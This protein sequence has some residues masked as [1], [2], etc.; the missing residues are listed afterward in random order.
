MRKLSKR[1][2][3]KLERHRREILNIIAERD[4]LRHSAFE[5]KIMLVDDDL[6]FNKFLER[7]FR[8][9]YGFRV[10]S[11]TD[12]MQVIAS[13]E[14]NSV[15][16]FVMD[17]N[18][19]TITGDKLACVVRVLYQQSQVPILFTSSNPSEE[20]TVCEFGLNHTYFLPKPICTKELMAMVTEIE[21]A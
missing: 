15:D 19:D 16:L 10:K 17:I 7:F 6:E 9:R 14:K 8:R 11:F 2:L 21:V 5:I 3:E 4:Y 13:L 18:L 1:K 12:E 20:L